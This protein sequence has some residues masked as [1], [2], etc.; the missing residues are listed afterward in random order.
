MSKEK[1]DIPTNPR[2]WLKFKRHNSNY[3]Q[4]WSK[5]NSHT[6]LVGMQNHTATLESS[7][8]ISYTIKDTLFIQPSNL[9]P[10]CFTQK[11]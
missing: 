10:R 5:W 1:Y 8:E 11:H 6:I 4:I 9:T 7:V 2:E 3:G